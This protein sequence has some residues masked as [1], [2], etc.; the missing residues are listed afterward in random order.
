MENSTLHPRACSLLGDDDDVTTVRLFSQVVA[1]S[2][3]N[4]LPR[5]GSV[6]A[7]L[8]M[9]PFHNDLFKVGQEMVYCTISDPKRLLPISYLS[10]TF[11]QLT[12]PILGYLDSI[13]E[14]IAGELTAR[15]SMGTIQLWSHHMHMNSMI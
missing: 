11:D 4:D 5:K 15:R 3:I 6:N 8:G 12:I 2:L 1:S 9:H 13:D 10:L 14:H 7:W